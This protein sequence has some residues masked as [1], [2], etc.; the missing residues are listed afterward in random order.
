MTFGSRRLT[1]RNRRFL[2]KFTPAYKPAGAPTGI[3]G[4]SPAVETPVVPRQVR[5]RNPQ[6]KPVKDYQLPA[7][8]TTSVI[9]GG[10]ISTRRDQPL[11]VRQ[12]D[13][14]PPVVHTDPRARPDAMPSPLAYQDPIPAQPMVIQQPMVITQP[15]AVTLQPGYQAVVPQPMPVHQYQQLQL[16]QPD[17]VALQPSYQEVNPGLIS[18]LTPPLRRSTRPTRGQTDKYKD[19]VQHLGYQYMDRYV[20]HHL[21]N[22]MNS[23]V[24]PVQQPVHVGHYQQPLGYQ[25]RIVQ[26][27][28]CSDC[29]KQAVMEVENNQRSVTYSRWS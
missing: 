21:L 11:P 3:S 12:E 1:L 23:P 18:P 16:P 24:G 19:Y 5:P 10:E 7:S 4:K 29:H 20:P 15:E 8:P 14:Q 17:A 27:R 22:Y 25:P 2:R 28:H 9:P 13:Y 26:P 6:A